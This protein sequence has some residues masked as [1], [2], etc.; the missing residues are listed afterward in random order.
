M[1]FSQS[2][3]RGGFRVKYCRSHKCCLRL[4]QP[5]VPGVAVVREQLFV[6]IGQQTHFG[7]ESPLRTDM[8]YNRSPDGGA[9]QVGA[10]PPQQHIPHNPGG[11]VFTAHP[12][13]SATRWPHHFAQLP[14]AHAVGRSRWDSPERPPPTEP[15]PAVHPTMKLS[16]HEEPVD[17]RSTAPNKPS[18]T[19][20]GSCPAPPS[21]QA[22]HRPSPRHPQAQY[23]ARPPAPSSHI[24]P[25]PPPPSL[26]KNSAEG[27]GSRTSSRQ[28]PLPQDYARLRGGAEQSAGA[29]LAPH[30]RRHDSVATSGG[31]E[32]TASKGG[33]WWWD[34]KQGTWK[35]WDNS[36]QNYHA[37]GSCWNH[38]S[39]YY[40]G[41][42]TGG[43]LQDHSWSTTAEPWRFGG[44]GWG[45][46]HQMVV[47]EESF[48]KPQIYYH[49][50]GGCVREERPSRIYGGWG[51]RGTPANKDDRCYAVTKRNSP[52]GKAP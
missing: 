29:P 18:S 49:L 15:S 6:L 11:L 44:L 27:G 3:R 48:L 45:G 7:Q 38:N 23:T 26:L 14:P 16:A 33:S 1:F 46:Q 32:N 28:A 25:P 42:T 40:P 22:P 34:Y 47:H 35:H 37:P 24:P 43:G 12:Y 5:P 4:F 50:G 17:H 51:H 36:R 30:S 39:G 19:N 8:W 10:G 52:H 13:G 9:G 21:E 2:E 41:W 20:H 31:T